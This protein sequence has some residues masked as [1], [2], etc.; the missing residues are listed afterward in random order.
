MMSLQPVFRKRYQG[1]I[2]KYCSLMTGF[3]FMK[4]NKLL[5]A[6]RKTNGKCFY[7]GKN[8]EV[9]DHFLPKKLWSDW[10]LNAC[11]GSVDQ[12]EN[13]ILAC[14]KCNGSKG[15]KHPYDFI[16]DKYQSEDEMWDVFYA[17]S[18]VLNYN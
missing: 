5:R 4:Q 14:R 11:I 13:L 10:E 9:I 18:G 17:F 15:S 6:F 7:C 16:G 1:E 3:C 12:D 2:P 8:G